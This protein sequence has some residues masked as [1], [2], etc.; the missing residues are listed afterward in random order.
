MAF[1]RATEELGKKFLC[2][3][4][5]LGFS[6]VTSSKKVP[7]KLLGGLPTTGNS[8][9]A[10]QTGSSYIT[11]TMIDSVEILTANPGFSTSTS[12]KK[13]LSNGCVDDRQPE[14]AIWPPKP[15]VLIAL[16][17]L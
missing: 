16:V 5:F 12:S 9:I 1:S 6:T 13:V 2:K 4:G 10:A 11:G 3:A 17:T 7:P 15:K 8:N 14:I